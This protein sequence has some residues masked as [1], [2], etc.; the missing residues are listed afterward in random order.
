[1]M[2]EIPLQTPVYHTRG[3]SALQIR[4]KFWKNFRFF[5]GAL[6]AI[7]RIS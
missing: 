1:M 6:T 5:P 2:L 4:M 7:P 3:T